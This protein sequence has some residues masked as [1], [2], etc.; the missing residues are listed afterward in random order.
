MEQSSENRI[1]S[2]SSVSAICQNCETGFQIEPEDFVFYKKMKVPAPTFCWKCRFA[3]RLAWRNEQ[4]LY[5][6]T[7]DLCKKNI[8]SMFKPEA[9]F[10][11]YCH[12][13]WWGD[14]WSPIEYGV[15]YNFDLPFF[16]QFA[17]LQQVVP[18]PALYATENVN[19]KYCNHSA[20]MKD[21][22]WVFGSWFSENC[23]YGQTILE[24]KDCWNCI[25]IKNCELCLSSFDCTKCYQTH[26]S[27]KCSSCFDSAFL[28]DCKNCQ[29]CIFSFNLR[30]KNYYAFN[31][32]V[33]KEE[34][35]KIKHETLS[36]SLAL[37]KGFGEFR[38]MIQDKTLH[39]FRSEEHTSELQSH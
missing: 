6:K 39:K 21:S 7:C 3:R 12:D 29:N 20:H 38:K 26:F 11:V 18:R 8:I 13:C 24:S 25:F 2:T 37:E 32:Q 17:K 4:S 19:S 9:P 30:N 23:G 22:Y 15:D 16:E 5:K 14:S 1:H 36:S 10:P 27:Q 33:S 28:Y 34:F 35:E 31:K